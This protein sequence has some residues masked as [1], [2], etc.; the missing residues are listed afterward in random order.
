[1]GMDVEFY[2]YKDRTKSLCELNFHCDSDE[3]FVLFDFLCATYE[4]N[5]VFNGIA[6]VHIPN[7]TKHLLF[8]WLEQKRIDNWWYDSIL[9]DLENETDDLIVLFD[10]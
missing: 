8:E 6:F 10:W 7:D 4:H 5:E 2:N 3:K 1:M 9:S